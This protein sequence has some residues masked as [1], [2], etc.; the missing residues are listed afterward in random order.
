MRKLNALQI[1]AIENRREQI[2]AAVAACIQIVLRNEKPYTF[3][4]SCP[5]YNISPARW[6]AMI[7]HVWDNSD[8]YCPAS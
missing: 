8:I 3:I 4:P 5:L 7:V 1:Q 6:R 2:N